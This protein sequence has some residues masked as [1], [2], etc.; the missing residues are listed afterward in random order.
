MKVNFKRGNLSHSWAPEGGDDCASFQE[1][2]SEEDDIHQGLWI[3]HLK[4]I[5]FLKNYN[6]TLKKHFNL[7]IFIGYDIY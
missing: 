5:C 4:K 3:L 2:N 7:S 1:A 6:Q